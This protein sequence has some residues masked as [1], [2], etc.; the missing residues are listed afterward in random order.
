[1]VVTFAAD[2]KARFGAFF[3]GRFHHMHTTCRKNTHIHMHTDLNRI[4]PNMRKLLTWKLEDRVFACFGKQD[5]ERPL[6]HAAAMLP[7][8]FPLGY[9]SVLN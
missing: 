5:I 8:H 9:L 6:G 1:M 4:E 3:W 7:E 2:K